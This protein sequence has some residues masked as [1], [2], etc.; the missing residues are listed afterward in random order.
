MTAP[1]PNWRRWE[2]QLDPHRPDG[3]SL[4]AGWRELTAATR[5]ATELLRLALAT[6]LVGDLLRPQS[7]LPARQ[8][9]QQEGRQ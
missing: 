7:L 1:E 8:D 6:L 4:R 5:R 3:D 2:R 9:E